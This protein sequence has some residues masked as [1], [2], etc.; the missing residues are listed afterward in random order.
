MIRATTLPNPTDG[1]ASGLEVQAQ[2]QHTHGCIATG[3]RRNA[4]F[5]PSSFILVSN[6]N[7]KLMLSKA[8][9]VGQLF[10]FFFKHDTQK[11]D[12]WTPFSDPAR[13]QMD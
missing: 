9:V 8:L 11:H 12:L 13:P 4:C 6:F 2:S 5:L 1:L 10:K 7:Q 3:I